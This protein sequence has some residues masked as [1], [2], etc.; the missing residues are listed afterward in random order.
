MERFSTYVN[1]GEPAAPGSSVSQFH[2]CVSCAAQYAADKRTDERK[3]VAN[4]FWPAGLLD[5]SQFSNQEDAET[6][7]NSVTDYVGESITIREL[8]EWPQ[9][10]TAISIMHSSRGICCFQHGC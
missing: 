10:R 6:I 4:C 3:I 9:E 2:I 8:F 7:T 5:A 1:R